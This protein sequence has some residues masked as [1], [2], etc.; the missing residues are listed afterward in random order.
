MGVLILF[1]ISWFQHFVFQTVLPT[2]LFAQ[3]I[4]FVSL[5]IS[6]FLQNVNKIRQWQITYKFEC[7]MDMPAMNYIKAKLSQIVSIC[8]RTNSPLH[9]TDLEKHREEKFIYKYYHWGMIF[10]AETAWTFLAEICVF[11]IVILKS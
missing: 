11:I 1:S 7:A 9:F 4:L 10:N 6:M 3:I 2:T 8:F 5:L